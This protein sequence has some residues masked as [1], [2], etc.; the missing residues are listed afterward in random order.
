MFYTDKN[1]TILDINEAFSRH[2]GHTKEEAVGQT[3]KILRSSHS[4]QEM[5]KRMWDGILSS[6]HWRGQLI[7]R[8]KAGRELPVFL[9]IT[10]VRDSNAAITGYVSSALDMSDQMALQNRVAQSEALASLG[11]MAAVVAH[12]IRNP[13]S[14]IVMAAKQIGSGRL[15]SAERDMVLKVLRDESQRLNET[16]TNFLAYARPRDLKLERVDLNHLI[17]EVCRMVQSNRDLLKSI[18]LKVSLDKSLEPFA[19]DADQLR[20]VV[21]NIML[22]AIQAMEGRGT[23]G[24]EISHGPGQ[25]LLCVTDT[26]PGIP[27]SAMATLFKPFHT[28]KRQGTGLGLAIAERIVKT[29]GGRIDVKSRQNQG[30]MFTIRLPIQE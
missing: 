24:L 9:T 25:A 23:L 2:Y 6:G 8:T 1:G 7:N 26:G 11:E 4:T 5:Y 18:E 14:S 22:N 20:Q 3:P 30:T 21:W 16:L 13:L 15:A 10:A 19:L 29:H 17:N 28:T 27:E 12:E